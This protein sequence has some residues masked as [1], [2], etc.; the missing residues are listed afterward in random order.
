MLITDSLGN[1]SLYVDSMEITL[2]S[3][4]RQVNLV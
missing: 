4:E 2:L 3:V 1:H